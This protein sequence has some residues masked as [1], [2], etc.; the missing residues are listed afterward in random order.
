MRTIRPSKKAIEVA[1][2]EGGRATE[3]KLEGYPYY[4]LIVS[5]TRKV[6][7]VRYNAFNKRYSK[8]FGMYPQ[9]S[10]QEFMAQAEAYIRQINQTHGKVD[11]RL[12]VSDFFDEYYHPHIQAKKSTY[13]DDVSK[14]NRYV[15][16]EIG[17][18]PISDVRAHHL[19]RIL[20]R[21]PEG[22]RPATINRY[23]ALL[24][25]L[26]E[27]A[28]QNELISR[29]PCKAIPLLSENNIIERHLSEAEG[30]AFIEACKVEINHPAVQV[31]M[32]CYFTG[33]RVGNARTLRR[34]HLSEDLSS[35]TILTKAGSDQTFPLSKNAQKLILHALS[36]SRGNYLFPSPLDDRKPVSYPRS[37]MRRICKRAGIA[38]A[39]EDID[40]RP[41]FSKEP[42]T[43]HGLRK[44]FCNRVMAETGNI[45]VCSELLGHSS[46]EVTRRYLAVNQDQKQ[47][48]VNAAFSAHDSCL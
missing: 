48:V 15:R 14:F 35:I 12:T 30:I 5:K 19:R 20:D 9:L 7:A 23:R 17:A 36:Q 34:E 25:A 13:R 3:Y 4:R 1:Q 16:P 45:Y 8:R 33:L 31:L 24:H 22:T 6:F 2:M 47:D 10:I 41:G 18:M 44:T 21:L 11:T 38:V 37:A 40:V 43:I 32:L 46:I 29:N 28:Y 27:Y 26:M 42:I 39:G